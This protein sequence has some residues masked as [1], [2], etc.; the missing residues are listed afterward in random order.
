MRALIT[1]IAG[2]AGS[3]LA[4]RL[5]D[6][7]G[8]E[9]HG[10]IHRH[11]WRIRSV[12]GQLHLHKGDLR[13]PSW[14]DELIREVQPDFLL[15]LAAWSDVGGS[16]SQPW[17]AYELN[18]H[19]QLN[20]LEA[21]RRFVPQCRVLVVGSNEVYGR[22]RPQELPV[23]EDTPFRPNSPYGVSKIAQD[24]MG[25]QYFCNYALPIVR[26][27]SFNN[28][29]P[30]QADDFVASAFARQIA[31][32]EA[33]QREAVIRVGNLAAVRDFTDV[34]DVVAAYWLLVQQG[35]AGAVYNVGRG[36]GHS[37]Q[38]ILEML[39]GMSSASIRVE[40]DPARLRPSDVP[41]MIC[42]NRRL[43]EAT[44]WQPRIELDRT[45]QDVLET[46]RR[47]ILGNRPAPTGV[48][49]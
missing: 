35:Q 39:L 6:E 44:G 36:Q 28:V 23:N 30:G 18:I 46:W 31:E 45:L 3:F 32:I 49:G 41:V 37:I 8:L 25:Y 26:A 38:T 17:V 11:D 33:G 42:D 47:D 1:G 48:S 43:V 19:C 15:H 29:G 2:F 4:Q 13:N 12:R 40:E 27:R 14:V 34:R 20:L 5:L 24:M 22:V 9:I 21:V 16:W 10:V 7:T